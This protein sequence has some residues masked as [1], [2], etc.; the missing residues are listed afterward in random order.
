[1]KKSV[2]TDKKFIGKEA[3]AT[4]TEVLRKLFSQNNE[5]DVDLFCKNFKTFFLDYFEIDFKFDREQEKFRTKLSCKEKE[6]FFQ[7]DY[8][9]YFSDKLATIILFLINEQSRKMSSDF[10]GRHV[11][12]KK[13]LTSEDNCGVIFPPIVVYPLVKFEKMKSREV[14][15]LYQVPHFRG[16]TNEYLGFSN[17][18]GNNEFIINNKKGIFLNLNRLV[19]NRKTIFPDH[20]NV[21]EFLKNQQLLE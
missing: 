11:P 4:L 16:K 8:K 21:A 2:F 13:Y 6:W 10:M 5:N 3:T 17:I 7:I 1:M 19:I 15:F 20:D 12:I 18:N 14:T 9:K